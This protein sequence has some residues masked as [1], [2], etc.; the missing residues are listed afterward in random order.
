MLAGTSLLCNFL[1]FSSFLSVPSYTLHP[2]VPSP[3]VHT[4]HH[5]NIGVEIRK[6]SPMRAS[7]LRLSQGQWSLSRNLYLSEAPAP[8]SSPPTGF[9]RSLA[10]VQKC[11]A[12]LLLRSSASLSYFTPDSLLQTLP[13]QSV[14]LSPHRTS[15]P[16]SL[17]TQLLRIWYRRRDRLRLLTDFFMLSPAPGIPLL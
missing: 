16:F 15:S 9:L 12:F 6:S 3:K 10:S 2:F 11:P 1:S 7:S 8:F 17:E 5:Q 14:N 13:S 4:V